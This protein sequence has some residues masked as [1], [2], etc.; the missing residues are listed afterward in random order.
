MGVHAVRTRRGCLLCSPQVL[1]LL[2]QIPVML[3]CP[4]HGCRL[5]PAN[6]LVMAE[7]LGHPI[8][9]T[10]AVSAAE[11]VVVMDRR[12]CEASTPAW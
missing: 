5:D 6:Y 3:S 1:L 7:A 4:E 9:E 10:A 2:A 11:A 12:T 8:D